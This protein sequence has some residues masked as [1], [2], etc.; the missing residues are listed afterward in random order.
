M[1]GCVAT[2]PQS[3]QITE[4]NGNPNRSR[5]QSC[6]KSLPSQS[7]HFSTGTTRIFPD[8]IRSISLSR[9]AL[10]ILFSLS[11]G[12]L[13]ATDQSS[14]P[15]GI[16][17]PV[18]VLFSVTITLASEHSQTISPSR[19]ASTP[20]ALLCALIQLPQWKAERTVRA[21]S[22]GPRMPAVRRR[23]KPRSCDVPEVQ[24]LSD[25]AEEG[26]RRRHWG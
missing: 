21:A 4:V 14:S 15:S 8:L 22:G 18:R 1:N 11:N 12:L 20:F 26:G 2:R 13:S 7:M 25:R 6:S 24:V 23:F 3:R 10:W 19:T 9:A 16:A 17:E 5:S